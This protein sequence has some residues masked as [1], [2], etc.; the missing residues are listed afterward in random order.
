MD[1]LTDTVAL[2]RHLRK[3]DAEEQNFLLCGSRGR[4]V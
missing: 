3:A 1:Y 4:C 2:V